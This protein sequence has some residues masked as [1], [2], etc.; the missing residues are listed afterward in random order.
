VRVG[1]LRARARV[2]DVHTR[3]R[4]RETQGPQSQVGGRVGDGAEHELDR[5]DDLRRIYTC[6]HIS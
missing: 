3:L 1:E 2:R 6:L 4:V 5:V